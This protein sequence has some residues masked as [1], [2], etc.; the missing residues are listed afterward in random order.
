MEK[1]H[2]CDPSLGETE[3]DC[4]PNLTGKSGDGCD[5]HCLHRIW[6]EGEMERG[7]K[8]QKVFRPNRSVGRRNFLKARKKEEIN[9]ITFK[10]KRLS[11]KSASTRQLDVE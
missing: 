1:N 5:L 7:R 4:L 6:I 11:M 9:G 10:I 3:N 8:E 2:H